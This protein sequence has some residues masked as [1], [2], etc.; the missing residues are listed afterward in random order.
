MSLFYSRARKGTAV[1]FYSRQLALSESLR[2]LD[3]MTGQVLSSRPFCFHH[4]T[5]QVCD[6]SIWRYFTCA[7]VRKI[8]IWASLKYSIWRFALR[9]VR[10]RQKSGA[11]VLA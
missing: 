1:R 10:C 11:I 8:S 4:S 3:G 9:C 7:H 5:C 2:R 6:A